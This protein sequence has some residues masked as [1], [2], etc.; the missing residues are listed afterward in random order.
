MTW[1][2]DH[3]RDQPYTKPEGCKSTKIQVWRNGFKETLELPRAMTQD[4]AEKY[5][6]YTGQ[7]FANQLHKN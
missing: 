6:N 4:E 2:Y 7:R 3:E 1:L 5:C